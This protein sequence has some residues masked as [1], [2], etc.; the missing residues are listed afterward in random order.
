MTKLTAILKS[1]QFQRIT[2]AVVVTAVTLA[3]VGIA[4]LATTPL[5]C[6]PANAMHVKFQA[7]RCETVASLQSPSASNFPTPTPRPTS[8]SPFPE[9]A[10]SYPIPDPASSTYDPNAS[11]NTFPY[12]DPASGVA[13]ASLAMNC[14]LPIF[15]GGSGSGGF[16]V[17]PG[18]SFQP[19]PRS[20][21]AAPS[22]S[23]SGVSPY[24]GQGWWG[25]TYDRAYSRWLPVPQAWVTP[26][27]KQ[28]A[29]PGSPDGIYVQNLATGTQVELGEGTSWAVLD[30]EAAGVYAVKGSLGGL[31][32]LP[33]TGGVTTITTSGFWQAVGGGAAYGTITSSVPSGAGNTIVRID[34]NSKSTTDYFGQPGVTSSVAGF[35]PNGKPVIFVQGRNGLQVWTDTGAGIKGIAEV[36][37]NRFYPNGPPL[38][39]NHGLWLA[40]NNGIALYV[41][42][43]GWWW[44]TSIGG[45]LAGGC[46]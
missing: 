20:A 33:F 10:S 11:S 14:R 41:Y 27:G 46:A 26:D 39:D 8:S 3:L 25:L 43:Q 40:G 9:P 1:P 45:Q 22:P 16:I 7:A 6:G 21:V 4:V 5:G 32:L 24:G 23:P 42:G 18:G 19:D 17:F 36:S 34:L 29:Y 35:G 28:Y 12:F 30:V 2:S 37:G 13:P 31:W 15:A 44:M 38:G